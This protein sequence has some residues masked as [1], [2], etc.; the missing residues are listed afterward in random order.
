MQFVLAE[1]AGTGTMNMTEPQ[2]GSDLA[3][4]R[5]KA[6]PQGDG[7][8]RIHGQKD[9]ARNHSGA[10]ARN[11][12]QAFVDFMIPIVKGCSTEIAQE[13]ASLGVQVHGATGFIEES[14]ATQHFRD[15]RFT[16]IHEDTT[17]IQANDLSLRA[18]I[19]TARYYAD[20]L[21]PQASG[22][23]QAVIHG[24]EAVLALDMARFWLSHDRSGASISMVVPAKAGTHTWSPPFVQASA[25][26]L[27]AGND[28]SHTSGLR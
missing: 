2:A 14:G 13:I 19:V 21:L 9:R 28:C 22:L 18:K 5:S 11:R 15:A 20:C 17:G 24:G 26:R 8:Y 4:V 25:V 12:Q 16:T 27:Q 6:V 10:D 1:L 3:A 23:A 7:T